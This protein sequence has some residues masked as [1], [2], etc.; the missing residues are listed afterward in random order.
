MTKYAGNPK[1]RP[2]A[3]LALKN[4]ALYTCTL[5]VRSLSVDLLTQVDLS[6]D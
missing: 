3:M 5:I 6:M 4:I 2:L 1:Q